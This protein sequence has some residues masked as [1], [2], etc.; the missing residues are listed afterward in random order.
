MVFGIFGCWIVLFNGIFPEGDQ[1]A[2]VI[3]E[4]AP[5]DAFSFGDSSGVAFPMR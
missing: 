2:G 3:Q 1:F 4:F 5:G